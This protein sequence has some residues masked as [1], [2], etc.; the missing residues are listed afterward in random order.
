MVWR[1]YDSSESRS[2]RAASRS[3]MPESEG[4]GVMSHCSLDMQYLLMP[5]PPPL[6]P[7]ELLPVLLL[8]LQLLLAI[9]RL[10]VMAILRPLLPLLSVDFLQQKQN[11]ILVPNETFPGRKAREMQLF[12]LAP[13]SASALQL[14]EWRTATMDYLHGARLTV[15]IRVRC[16]PNGFHAIVDFQRSGTTSTCHKAVAIIIAW[17]TTNKTAAAATAATADDASTAAIVDSSTH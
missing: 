17:I 2:L 3:E 6:P 9:V 10:P 14:T 8:L 1:K 4:E 7:P 15:D 5:P 13:R 12:S 11:T 16:V